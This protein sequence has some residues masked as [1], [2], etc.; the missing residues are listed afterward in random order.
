MRINEVEKE[1][2]QAQLDAL[3]TVLD[4]VFAQLGIDVEFTRHFLDR[5]ND[6]RNMR[7]ITIHEL[8]QL[9]KKEFVKWGKPIARLGPDAE[10]VM[11]DLASDINIPFA[12][13]W[14]KGSGMLEL[15]AKTVMRKRNFRTPNQEFPVETYTLTTKQQKRI[16]ESFI[17]EAAPAFSLGGLNPAA[18][19][20]RY[21]VSPQQAANAF[22]NIR[23]L[24]PAFNNPRF[25][26]ALNQYLLNNPGAFQAANENFG[27]RGQVRPSLRANLGALARGAAGRM[28]GA[29]GLILTPTAAGEGEDVQ[30][31]Q[32]RQIQDFEQFL[33]STDPQ[34][35][36]ELMDD[37]ANRM[38]D[39]ELEGGFD[40]RRTDAY[41]AAEE[42]AR[43]I[44]RQ[45]GALP[46]RIN[47]EAPEVDPN[48][49]APAPA[50][51]TE[52]GPV[53]PRPANDPQ[54]PP[55]R[56]VPPTAPEVDPSPRPDTTPPEPLPT[57]K[58]P[59]VDPNAPEQEPAPE[60]EPGPITQPSPLDRPSPITKPSPLD[61]PAVDGA[62]QVDISPA[63]APVLAPAP[64]PAPAT[65]TTP[66]SSSTPRPRRMRR[67]SSDGSPY[68]DPL[69][70]WV[71]QWGQNF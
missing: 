23:S 43:M 51:E 39:Q 19:Q 31:A 62:P 55:L 50:P 58:G 2:T 29:I 20:Q 48:A 44:R 65:A 49:P 42:A 47:P 54:R 41:R 24:N 40:P 25:S 60:T 67:S 61:R 71:R 46:Q 32:M 1:V 56:V 8:A 3:E 70:R 33:L 34:A 36:K 9:F 66:P 5:V 22:N 21:S 59:E 68:D 13:N 27:P 26:S 18:F 10:A 14:N 57:P 16:D 45:T 12:L 63:S 69:Q 6:E 35:Y 7:Q 53:L 4:R 52:P 38:S 17:A 11:K 64:V 28:L 30:M 15:V 37:Y